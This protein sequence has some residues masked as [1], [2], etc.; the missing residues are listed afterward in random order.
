MIDLLFALR[1][2]TGTTLLLITHDRG[3]AARC[4]RQVHLSDGKV[5]EGKVTG[6]VAP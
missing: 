3:L 6:A 5:T 4:D 1:Q 2:R